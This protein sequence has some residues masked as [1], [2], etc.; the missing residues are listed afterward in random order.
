MRE[1]SPGGQL[2]VALDV[3]LPSQLAVGSGTALFVRGSCRHPERGIG[4]LRLVAGDRSVPVLAHGISL[5]G[6]PPRSGFWGVVPFEGGSAQGRTELRLAAT[7]EGGGTVERPLGTVE[8]APDLEALPGTPPRPRGGGARIAICMATYNPP[9][10]LFAHQV[11]SIRTQTADDWLCVISDDGSE[12]DRLRA[13]EDAVAGDPR[14]MLF[15]SAERLGFYRNFERA[16]AIV[17]TDVPY[18]ALADQDDRWEP[19]KLEVLLG[20]L[21]DA[22]LVY[23]DARAIR[24]GGEPISE[25]LWGR[26]GNNYTNLASLLISNSVTG[27]ASLFRREL[28]DLALPLPPAPG[29]PFHDHW[30]A[31]VALACGELAYVDRPLLDYVQHPGAVIGYEA[32]NPE[33]EEGA[34]LRLRRLIAEPSSALA[35]WRTAYFD[36]YCRTL[37]FATVLRMRCASM[38]TPLKRRDLNRFLAGERSPATLAWLALRP[39]RAVAG[40]NETAGFEYRLLR[41]LVWRHLARGQR[42]GYGRARS[43]SRSS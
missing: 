14:F 15:P 18:V 11:E 36:D 25:S 30:L 37:L 19:R 21:G 2:A 39:L 13:I 16:L 31:L 35:R 6:R 12:P 9:E 38:L 41:G 23:S 8:L 17:P 1:P 4:A 32:I 28:L 10:D 3:E 24:P 27:A 7:L 5:P 42:A 26:R 43:S 22:Q 40:R 29:N 34:A 20:R 33:P